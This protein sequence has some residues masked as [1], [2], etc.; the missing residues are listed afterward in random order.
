MRHRHRYYYRLVLRRKPVVENMLLYCR[1]R[2]DNHLAF[3]DD[4]NFNK[5]TEKPKEAPPQLTREMIACMRERAHEVAGGQT[6]GRLK[7]DTDDE[8]KSHIN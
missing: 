1:A 5:Q 2:D 4:S 6:G 7:N 8:R 3:V